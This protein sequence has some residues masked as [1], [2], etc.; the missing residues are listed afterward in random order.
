MSLV[1]YQGHSKVMVNNFFNVETWEM[2][3]IR[4]KARG[5]HLLKSLSG[6]IYVQEATVRRQAN[7]AHFQSWCYCF[8]VAYRVNMEQT[9]QHELLLQT[10]N[11]LLSVWDCCQLWGSR[12]TPSEH[13]RSSNLRTSISERVRQ[14][15]DISARNACAPLYIHLYLLVTFTSA[16]HMLSNVDSIF[17]VATFLAKK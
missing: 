10:V 13:E 1:S 6:G 16:C 12:R 5:M 11:N 17:C 9:V 14:P 3:Y 7:H 15:N 8:I 2:E 4:L